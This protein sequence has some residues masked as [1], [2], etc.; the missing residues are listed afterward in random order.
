[1]TE[2]TGFEHDLEE[3]LRADT[4]R[5]RR[6]KEAL[7][8]HRAELEK[9]HELFVRTAKALTDEV[10][11]P[12]VQKLAPFF[13]NAKLGDG[14]PAL[15]NRCRCELQHTA[16]FPATVILELGVFHDEEIRNVIL[17]CDTEILPIFFKFT[18]RHQTSQPLE[19]IDRAKLAAWVEQ[20]LMEFVDTYLRLEH[21][22][23]YQQE[24]LVTDPVCGARIRKA[25]AGSKH[26]YHGVLYY[27]C[28]DACERIFAEAPDQYVAHSKT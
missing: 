5:N 18:P 6:E 12:R 4:E 26:E 16:R 22:D 28:T 11:Q 15:P 1:M 19:A 14:N 23:Q 10:I 25:M 17:Y 27:F 3:K 8:E 7:I 24:T 13:P 9:R 20:Q 21:S 2:L